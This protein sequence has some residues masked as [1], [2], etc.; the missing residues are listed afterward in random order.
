MS[1]SQTTDAMRRL[2]QAVLC[3][4]IEVV[5]ETLRDGGCPDLALGAAAA[6]GHSDI[7]DLLLGAGASIAAR[8]C[9]SIAGETPL[10]LTAC[11]GSPAIAQR[12][13]DAGA[14]VNAPTDEQHTPLHFFAQEGHT[15]GWVDIVCITM[16]LC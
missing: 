9:G 13:I 12:L 1:R 2:D 7:V 5:E 14:D 6:L 16:L 15:A 3:G 11:C 8:D 10:Y 4:N